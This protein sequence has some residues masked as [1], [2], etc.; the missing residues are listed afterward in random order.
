MGTK[1][2]RETNSIEYFPDENISKGHFSFLHVIG[3]GGF[4]KVW[5]VKHKKSK[6]KF[7]LK[8]M[9]KSKILANKSLFSVMNEK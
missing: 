3:K 1:L 6:L 5:K 2:C 8:E 9:I 7:A 4:S